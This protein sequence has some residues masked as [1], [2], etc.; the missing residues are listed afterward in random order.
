MHF[1]KT[2]FFK[3]KIFLKELHPQFQMRLKHKK[4][5]ILEKKREPKFLFLTF[6]YIIDNNWFL[7]P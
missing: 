3:I 1:R 5:G 7:R 2:E 4:S 6:L